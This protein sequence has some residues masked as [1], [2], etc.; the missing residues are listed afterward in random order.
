[1]ISSAFGAALAANRDSFNARMRDARRRAPALS[2]ESFGMFLQ[3]SVAPLVDAVAACQPQRVAAVVDAAYDAA[4][5]LAVRKLVGAGARSQVLA[6]AWAS[7]FLAFAPL[8]AAHPTQILGM[9]SNAIVYLETVG[10]T[11]PRQWM[12]EMAALAPR[13]ADAAHLAA[14]GQIV[15]WR[16]GAAH[17]RDGAI[18]AADTLP[19]S[20]ALAALCAPD[21]VEL[22]ALLLQMIDDPWWRGV[23][24]HARDERELGEFTGFGGAFG[25]PPQVRATQD[26]F[27]VRAADRFFFLVVDAYG[28]VLQPAGPDDFD[29]ADQGAAAHLVDGGA[30]HV[31]ARRIGFD[32]PAAGLATC[33][34]RTTLAIVSPYTHAI[35]LLPR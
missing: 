28:A 23:D 14:L 4:L 13:I 25:T 12:A 21:G 20:L 7:T 24:E 6:E 27:V 35:R 1:M 16:A 18:A 2:S 29:G 11:R 5:A 8:I 26:G 19:A 31:G 32:L 33:V 3:G 22:K 30:L 34:N 10:G 17:F 9:L 15:A